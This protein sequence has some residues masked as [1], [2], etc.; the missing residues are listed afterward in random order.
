MVAGTPVG[1]KVNVGILRKGTPMTVVVTLAEFPEDQAGTTDEGEEEE[2]APKAGA[3]QQQITGLGLTVATLTPDLRKQF[4]IANEVKGVVIT[5]V[6]PDAPAQSRQLRPGDLVLEVS[7][8]PVSTPAD[9]QDRVNTAKE[10]GQKAVL[11]L[12]ERK[13]EQTFLALALETEK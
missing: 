13:G 10:A 12:V 6:S 8:S 11:L 2:A 3:A 5:K 9:V 1:T 7:Q 4:E